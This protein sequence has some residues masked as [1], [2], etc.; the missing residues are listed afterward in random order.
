MR[1][2]WLAQISEEALEPDLEICD[3]HHHLWHRPQNSYLLDEV[4]G[5][6]NSGHRVTSTVFV[7]CYSMY[8]KAANA[9]LA[10]V[11]ET[12][13]VQG[14]AAMSASGGF[15]ETR[16]ADGI[17]SFADLTLGQNVKPVLEAHIQASINR[18]RGIR[19]SA[20]WHTSDDIPNS[21][22]NPPN[23]LYL[24]DDFR[25]GMAVLGDL[26]LSFDAWLYHFQIPDFVDLARAFPKVVMIL[27]H[28]GGPINIGPYA[29]KKDQVFT[30]WQENISELR[31][32]PNVN[33]KLG[34]INMKRN[35]FDWHTRK[36]PASSDE[37]VDVTAPYYM[38]CID[39]FGADRCM[40]ESN[41]PVDKDSCSY[42]VL[43]NAFKKMTS[44][45]SEKEKRS[46]FHDTA[47][48]VYRLEDLAGVSR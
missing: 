45:K 8:Q 19:H 37:L 41:F 31:D 17:V 35:G 43:W 32:C 24:H 46:L 23:Q 33:F 16:I 34:G 4:L 20:C 5:D 42:V 40:F 22:S 9:E 6:V 25:K 18:F 21:H 28:F 3:P 15:G 48:R 1:E 38:H 2:Q 12:E 14:I 26:G 47:H 39:T 30:E 7:E 13:F 10:P 36:L 27:D 29:G 44:S 11:G